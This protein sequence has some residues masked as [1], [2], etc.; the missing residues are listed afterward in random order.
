MD[1]FGEHPKYLR[2]MTS[3]L[4][5]DLI[6]PS[7]ATSR[8]YY[9]VLTHIGL[10]HWGRYLDRYR[11]VDGAWRFADRRVTLDGRSEHALF[12]AP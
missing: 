5:I 9:A 7:S 10:D 8:C 11:A 12:I 6:D 1:G 3:T 4:Q 2:H